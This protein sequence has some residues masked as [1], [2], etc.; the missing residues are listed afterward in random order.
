MRQIII[1]HCE[2]ASYPTPGIKI[3]IYTNNV[4]VL[5]KKP[6]FSLHVRWAKIQKS[7]VY[8]FRTI[9]RKLSVKMKRS[10]D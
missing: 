7:H 5:F 6:K 3:K 8:N 2:A 4:T 1:T 9:P 10:Y